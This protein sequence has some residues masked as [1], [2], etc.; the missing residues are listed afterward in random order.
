[1][2]LLLVALTRTPT[3]P[4]IVAM[5][6]TL[7]WRPMQDQLVSLFQ[8]SV[9]D[10]RVLGALTPAWL[11]RASSLRT[12]AQLLR[13][14]H[15]NCPRLRNRKENLW[16]LLAV[17]DHCVDHP[18][19]A[20]QSIDSN[21][22]GRLHAAL[23]DVARQH[24]RKN[25]AA[26]RCQQSQQL[27]MPTHQALRTI[28]AARL[29]QLPQRQ[30][31]SSLDAVLAPLQADEAE[32]LGTSA[33]MALPER[34]GM[35]VRR[36]WEAPIEELV[37]QR[38]IPSGEV[39]A[40]VALQ[41]T[42]HVHASS[43]ADPMLRRLYGATYTA[44][45]KRR[46]LLLLNLQSQVRIEE[47]P[48]VEA[49]ERF[50]VRTST[51]Q[52][53]SQATLTQLASVALTAFPG[54]IL[55]NPLL[56]EL[57]SLAKGAGHTLP[58]VEEIAADIFMGEFTSKFVLCAQQACELVRGTWYARYYDIAP[59]LLD[60]RAHDIDLAAMCRSRARLSAGTMGVAANGMVIEQQQILTTH[61]LAL[62]LGPLGLAATLSLDQLSKDAFAYLCALHAQR[63]AT[64]RARLHRVKNSAYAWR[65]LLFF[66][67]MAPPGTMEAWLPWAQSLLSSQPNLVQQRLLP[68]LRGLQHIVGGGSFDADV[69][70]PHGARR[71]VGWTTGRHWMINDDR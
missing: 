71:L 13:Q 8:D 51:S 6:A 20:D 14:Q 70:A 30:G 33:G 4:Q 26:I 22:R 42:A 68:V 40:E 58:W 60:G 9:R 16:L 28:V 54:V 46:S 37:Q 56:R 2:V 3:R 45:R 39:L 55:P 47:L 1:M 31:L 43:F 41:L 59:T 61:N 69:H 10:G 44:F 50:R 5:R 23:R 17:L 35:V 49:M 62:L 57:S 52:A 67:S 32:A 63:R 36:S 29:K 38:I 21:L 24:A 15:P 7:A 66:V 65:Q 18:H 12:A 64:H 48:W 53:T 27:Q 34:V 11:A 25:I 19:D